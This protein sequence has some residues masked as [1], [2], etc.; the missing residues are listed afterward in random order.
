[1]IVATVK[2]GG[3]LINS[4]IE[5]Y[6]YQGIMYRTSEEVVIERA[7]VIEYLNKTKGDLGLNLVPQT[8]EQ[9]FLTLH[10]DLTKLDYDIQLQLKISIFNKVTAQQV[11]EEYENKLE[12]T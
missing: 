2:E 7:K 4:F 3:V 12:E 6:L 9:E 10:L 5:G 1:M 8:I 11:I